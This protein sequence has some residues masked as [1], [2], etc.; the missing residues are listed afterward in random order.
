MKPIQHESF[1]RERGGR[2]RYRAVLLVLLGA[3]LGACNALDRALDVEAPSRIPAADLDN[4]AMAQLRVSGAIADFECAFNAYVVVTGMVGEEFMDAT[5]TADRWPYDRREVQPNDRRYAE[6]A[7]QDLGVYTPLS[8]ARWA[9]ES[10]L[11][12][13]ERDWTDEQMPAGVTRTSLIATAAAYSGYSHLLLAEGFCSGVLLD[14]SLTPGAEAT[15]EQ[16]FQRA[17]E[18]FTRAIQAAEAAGNSDILNMARVGRAR[19]RLNLN[20]KAEA[21]ADARLV[22]ANYVR[23][24]TAAEQPFRRVNRVYSQNGEG[25]ALSI[26]PEYR[27]L[28]FGGVPD[29]RVRVRD[30]GRNATDG[31]RIWVQEKYTSLSAPIPLATW[32]E[33]QLIVAEAELDAGNLQEAV[34]IINALHTRE[35]VGLP[36]FNSTDRNQIMQQL[37]E[38]RRRELFLESHHLGDVIRYGIQLQP[39]TGTVFPK[40]G[41][42]G[43]TTC[44]PLPNVERL[45]NPN[46]EV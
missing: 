7:C 41:L 26:A 36:A 46:I 37:I 11:Q 10:V 22:P 24:V 32:R 15:R 39:A 18:R 2:G 16:I 33:A 6:F 28:D 21:A 35:G 19:T 43:N 13:L 42:Y 17:D 20:R 14:E 4:P 29:P 9:A 27:N 3:A 12:K 5:Q 23:N 45:N 38:E 31:T 40:G 1:A 30:T 8:T 34:N 44:L 25:N